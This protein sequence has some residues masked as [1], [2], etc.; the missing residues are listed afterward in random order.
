MKN[1]KIIK[2]SAVLLISVVQDILGVQVTTVVFH[3]KNLITLSV[4]ETAKYL[5]MT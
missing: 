1:G 3:E 4:F 2:T 5:G